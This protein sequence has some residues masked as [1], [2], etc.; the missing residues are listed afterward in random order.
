VAAAARIRGKQSARTLGEGSVKVNAR[1]ARGEQACR[2]AARGL[3]IAR[4]QRRTA[5]RARIN[6]AVKTAMKSGDK[7]RLATLRL[8]TAAIKD[9]DLAQAAGAAPV[10]D[11]EII[12]VLQKMLKQRR[13]SIDVY[14][15]N[16][17]E[18]LAAQ[19]ETEVAVI[20]EYMPKQMDEGE[21]RAAV[22]TL[23]AEVGAS[24]LKDMGR[25]MA[26]LKEK[27]AGTMDFGKASAIVKEILQ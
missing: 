19:E 21:T 12:A 14:R 5:M 27:H 22:T 8:I 4:N 23:V 2:N 25:V 6:E 24:G 9:R 26:A 3:T 13:E 11:S 17:R 20:E 15:K 18:E 16:G 1:Q 7:G 10:G